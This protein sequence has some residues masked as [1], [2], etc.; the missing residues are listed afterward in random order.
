MYAAP[1]LGAARL[2]APA[3]DLK[4]ATM[5]LFGTIARTL[6]LCLALCTALRTQE[7]KVALYGP[8][9]SKGSTD[10]A[11]M[12][13]TAKDK[14]E[15]IINSD[16]WFSL[17][18]REQEQI[19]TLLKEHAV[20]SKELT[21]DQKRDLDRL[22]VDYVFQYAVAELN[23]GYRVNCALI[24]IKTGQMMG[25]KA[26]IV[27]APMPEAMSEK[28]EEMMKELLKL[29][30]VKISAGG[31]V[32]KGEVHPFLKDLDEELK[33]I[34][35]DIVSIRKWNQVKDGS[36]L[37]V[38]LSGATISSA[39]DNAHPIYKVKGRIKFTLTLADKNSASMNF[40]VPEL[41]Q[42]D[43]DSVRNRIEREVK[44]NDVQIIGDLLNRLD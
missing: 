6:A 12:I 9:P 34:I 25:S 19:N 15:E 13:L 44:K 8:D 36:P 2:V 33:E 16:E 37:A 27:P 22:G 41:T 26:G 39:F 21:S 42:T 5:R 32:A 3:F 31:L 14:F 38:D 23:R 11:D 35:Q 4:G 43:R 20:Q 24:D 10:L 30:K 1:T 7:V 17:M 28:A 40:A 29:A 18:V